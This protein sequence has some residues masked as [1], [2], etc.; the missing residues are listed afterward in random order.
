MRAFLNTPRRPDKKKRKFDRQSA[1]K[2]RTANAIK[3]KTVKRKKNPSS[4]QALPLRLTLAVL[5][6]ERVLI[7]NNTHKSGTCVI[8][9]KIYCSLKD[10]IISH[11]ILALLIR[12]NVEI[13]LRCNY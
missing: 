8:I 1:I 4:L 13:K 11:G 2:Q 7:K 6:L 12:A 10:H 5:I 9:D 3:N